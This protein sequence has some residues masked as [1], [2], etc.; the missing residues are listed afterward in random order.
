MIFFVIPPNLLTATFSSC[1][2]SGGITRVHCSLKRKKTFRSDGKLSLIDERLLRSHNRDFKRLGSVNESNS[3]ICYIKEKPLSCTFL[4]LPW[5][6]KN[7]FLARILKDPCKKRFSWKILKESCK[8]TFLLERIL[9]GNFP[10]C[11]I[12]AR[13]LAE[14]SINLQ[15]LARKSCKVLVRNAFFSTRVSTNGIKFGYMSKSLM[16]TPSKLKSSRGK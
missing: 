12:L 4:E 5:L 14:K 6:T 16:L 11:K 8:E 9:Q 3:R 2:K 7:A 13:C 15:D 1:T 10:P